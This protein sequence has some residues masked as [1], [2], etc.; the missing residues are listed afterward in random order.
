MAEIELRR[1]EVAG[2][3]I[4]NLNAE[5][6]ERSP[7]ASP[8]PALASH[9]D[10]SESHIGDGPAYL[11]EN[12]ALLRTDP[13]R[14]IVL[15]LDGGGIRGLS[16]LYILQQL[17]QKIKSEEKRLDEAQHQNPDS[18]EVRP[19]LTSASSSGLQGVATRQNAGEDSQD[20][21]LCHYFDFM[22]GTSTGG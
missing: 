9:S 19:V 13:W 22:V 1:V 2:P 21:R 3:P 6:S 15:S 10:Q 20:R 8:G 11:R 18:D 14:P 5:P 12:P 4:P 17:M 16:S 7:R